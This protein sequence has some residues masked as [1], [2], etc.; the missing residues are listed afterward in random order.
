MVSFLLGGGIRAG[1]VMR[2]RGSP[3]KPIISHGP[4]YA[5]PSRHSPPFSWKRH[6]AFLPQQG[7][8]PEAVHHS[9]P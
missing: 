9:Q 2:S 8:M 4:G 1:R 6:P 5:D 7:E 3:E